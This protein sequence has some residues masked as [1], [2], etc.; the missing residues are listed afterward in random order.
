MRLLGYES[1]RSFDKIIN[2]AVYLSII[3]VAVLGKNKKNLWTIIIWAIFR[4]TNYYWAW[5]S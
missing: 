5:V 3:S 2:T 1:D 4:K